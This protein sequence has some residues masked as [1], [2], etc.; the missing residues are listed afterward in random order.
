MAEILTT[1]AELDEVFKRLERDY[2]ALSKKQQAYA[3]REIGRIRAEIADMLADFAGE[4][5]L[6]KRQRLGRVLRDLDAI[7]ASMRKTG[8]D[9]LESI[10]KES[11]EWTTAQLA[12]AI[13]V[14]SSVQI[15]VNRHVFDYMVKR[16]E[17]DGLVLSDR[18]WGMSGEIRDSLASVLRSSII[19][20]EGISAMISKI[21]RV[22]NAETWKIN[23]LART[24]SVTAKRAATSYNAQESD[25]VKWVRLHEGNCGRSDHHE[26]KCHELAHLDRYKQGKGIFKP[27][28]TD[29][30]LPHPN[31]TSWISYVLDERWL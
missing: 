3:V 11:S 30:W 2:G 9:S 27:T 7:E 25:I 5:G 4:D 14:G 15:G 28:D 26:H 18:V 10:I 1:Q 20:G 6:I 19:K 17:S 21:R 16:F 8:V 12:G 22:F 13:G 23:R 24:E 31:C 29:I